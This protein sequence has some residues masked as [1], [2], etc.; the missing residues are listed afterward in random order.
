MRFKD[1][2][3]LVGIFFLLTG[4]AQKKD[5]VQRFFWPPSS[6]FPKIEYIG[7]IQSDYDL[8]KKNISALQE[9]I[10]GREKPRPLF[11]YPFDVYSDAE[12][13]YVSEPN[14]HIVKVVDLAGGRV[15]QLK[16]WEGEIYF[17]KLPM[18]VGGD[19]DGRVYVAD[20][21]DQKIILFDSE[22]RIVDKWEGRHLSRPV[23]LTI[24]DSR[25]RVYVVEPDQHKI[26][27][28]SQN[29][30]SLISSFG[31][32]GNGPGEF[33]FPLDVDLDEKGNVYVL[34][35]LN[36]RIQLFDPE[37]HFIRQF[38]ERGTSLGSFKLPKSI[39][40]SSSGHVFVADSMAHRFVVFDL[41]GRYLLTVGDRS[42]AKGGNVIPGGFYLPQGLDVDDKE[43]IW[44][45]D[46]LNRIIHHFQ[47]LTEDYLKENPILPGQAVNPFLSN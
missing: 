17:F 39:E 42:S 32:R 44:V 4:C 11:S 47:Y 31:S 3:L 27:I 14:S 1:C 37:G 24:D 10:F 21:L 8:K 45:V 6:E 26:L 19:K 25:G 15:D 12:K 33:N 28:L 9:A 43:R 20:S 38:G 16:N 35:S 36:A 29:D 22:G 18:G 30:G 5:V 2:A 41:E 7:F 40:V 46:T 13:L 34:D 23:N